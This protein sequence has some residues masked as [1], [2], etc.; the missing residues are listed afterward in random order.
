[1]FALL[2]AVVALAAEASSPAPAPTAL[3][4]DL[5]GSGRALTAKVSARGKMARLEIADAK[6][7]RLAAADAPAPS[8]APAVRLA[9]GSLGSPGTLIEVVAAGPDE[10]CRSFWRFREG[11]LVRLPA[12][13]GKQD[14][15]D[16]AR[17]DGWT[18]GWEKK[19]ADAPAV[20]VRER[21][22]QTP[23]GRHREREVYA[24]SGFSLDF[25]PVRSS[26]E[27]AG[28]AIPTWN[29]AILYTPTALENLSSR[30]DFTQFRA[31]PRL[32]IRADRAQ[33]LFAL[34]FTDHSG[35]F[36][37]A[38]TATAPGID[39]NEID[40]TLRAENGKASARVTLRGSIVT[41][42][43][44]AGVSSRW[45][46][47]YQPASRFTG[48]ALEVYSRAE[49]DLASNSLVG[50]W[51][52]DR[53]EQLAMNLAPGLLGVIDM[54]RSQLDVSLDPVPAGTDVLLL[55]RDGATPAWA[56]VLKGANG[57]GRVPVRCESRN[58][59]SWS[60]ETAGP[61]EAFHRVG[62]RMNAR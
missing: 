54:R 16:C 58:A 14:L 2:I 29:D 33:G 40:L 19:A 4:A 10:E 21:E 61:A 34:E 31:A 47:G 27:I 45:D 3:T 39:S 11:A 53:G 17:P 5:D 7:K 20:W 48:A 35:R 23:R 60:C 9:G 13:R 28:V 26:G 24:F 15:P 30:F 8:G 52:S 22:R 36:E 25:D 37:A 50:L 44:I 56:L 51:A 6:G 38:V 55:P 46:G 43:R 12:H 49:D 41:E 59:G 1:V 42:V 18:A 57:I 62:G 32:R